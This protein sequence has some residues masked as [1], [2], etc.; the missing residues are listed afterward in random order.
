[1]CE[2]RICF[3]KFLENLQIFG[4]GIKTLLLFGAEKQRL[5]VS[6]WHLR[7]SLHTFLLTVKT[8]NQ[9]FFN[10]PLTATQE[11][12]IPHFI[13]LSGIFFNTDLYSFPFPLLVNS[14]TGIE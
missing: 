8:K 5:T 2:L 12:F 13:I 14:G 11:R 3:E 10:T 1:V 9:D 7:Q 4:D 6:N